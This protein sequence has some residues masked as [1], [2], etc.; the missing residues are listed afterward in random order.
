[1]ELRN[2]HTFKTIV[3]TG[4]FARAAD[5][6]GYTQSTITVHI[7]QLERDLNVKLFEK[8]GR[9]MV[10]T[11]KG[12]E[13]LEQSMLLLDMAAELEESCRD[14][15]EPKGTL[16]IAAAETILCYLLPPIIKQFRKEAPNVSLKIFNKTCAQTPSALNDGTCDLA[17][18]YHDGWDSN[19]F[20]ATSLASTPVLPIAAPEHA[21]IDLSSEHQ[22]VTLPFIIDEPDSVIRKNFSNYLKRRSITHEGMIETW[23][24]QAIKCCVAM[25]MGFTILPEF[26]VKKELASKELIGLNWKPVNPE[27]EIFCARKRTHRITPAMSLFLDILS[28][29][30]SQECR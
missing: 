23:S 6:L 13:I 5:V 18:T 19:R 2:L 16:K 15:D 10:L 26:V 22:N 11:D 12:H 4:S 7:Q 9:R 3:E 25:G 30:M 24:T 17:L 28:G 8:V 14:E 1:M 20:D 27:V 29:H 21:A